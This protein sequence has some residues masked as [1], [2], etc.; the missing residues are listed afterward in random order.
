MSYEAYLRGH[1]SPAMSGGRACRPAT[2]RSARPRVSPRT[3]SSCARSRAAPT[4]TARCTARRG[5]RPAR[6]RARQAAGLRRRPAPRHARL[7]PRADGRQRQAHRPRRARG[8]AP[9]PRAAAVPRRHR[10]P[11]RGRRVGRARQAE[12]RAPDGQ[13]RAAPR[14]ARGRSSCRPTTRPRGAAIRH[15]HPEWVVRMWWDWLGPE[16]TRA[17][18]IADNEPAELALRVNAL[19]SDAAAAGR[20][21]GRREGEAILVDGAFD[22]FAPSGL[23]GRRVHAAVARRAARRALPGSAARRA[24]ARPLRGAGRQDDAPRRADGGQR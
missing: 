7:D 1:G 13:R 18:L 21:P 15:A 3:P 14:A 16:R 17:L 4:P 8:A 9:R 20:R 23:R 24:R 5:P 2:G 6:P 11:R 19:A 10:R 12:P 22:A